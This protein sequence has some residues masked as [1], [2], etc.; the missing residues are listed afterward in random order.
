MSSYLQ[1]H[2]FR[3]LLK[4]RF[5]HSNESHSGGKAPFAPSGRDPVCNCLMV[6][7]EQLCDLTVRQ[8]VTVHLHRLS[9]QI[10]RIP[11]PPVFSHIVPLAVLAL[12]ALVPVYRHACFGL[13]MGMIAAW[14]YSLERG[15][16]FHLLLPPATGDEPR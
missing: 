7:G 6:Y 14:A 5:R 16:G 9:A 2:I 4:L 1:E 8:P 15:Y 10:R 13:T 3:N 11:K 12:V